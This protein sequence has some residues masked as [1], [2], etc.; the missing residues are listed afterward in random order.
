MVNECIGLLYE[1]LVHV[2]FLP[3]LSDTKSNIKQGEKNNM[4]INN[5]DK[6]VAAVAAPTSNSKRNYKKREAIYETTFSFTDSTMA[7]VAARNG[8][9]KERVLTLGPVNY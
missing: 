6:A 8:V 2:G 4:T 9:K 1:Y 3:R 7:R 5:D